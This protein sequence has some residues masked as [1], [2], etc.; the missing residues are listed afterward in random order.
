M[1]AFKDIPV[2]DTFSF[3]RPAVGYAGADLGLCVKISARRYQ[4]MGRPTIYTVG[5]V[6]VEV[7]SRGE[8]TPIHWSKGYVGA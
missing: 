6:N 2:N 3:P 1:T 5:A 4:A 8:N 7:E